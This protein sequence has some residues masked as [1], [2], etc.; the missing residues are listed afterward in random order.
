MEF[1]NFKVPY[2]FIAA[3]YDRALPPSIAAAQ[4][5][6]IPNLTSREVKTGH[7]ALTEDPGTVIGYLDEWLEQVVFGGKSKL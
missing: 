3:T 7:W 5:A 2:L 1:D 6:W 4:V